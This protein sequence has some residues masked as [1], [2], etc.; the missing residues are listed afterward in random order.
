MRTK[1]N[2]ISNIKRASYVTVGMLLG[3]VTT[4]T[5]QTEPVTYSANGTVVTYSQNDIGLNM[6]VQDARGVTT[7]FQANNLNLITSEQSA[8]RGLTQYTYDDAGNIIRQVSE[9]GLVFKRDYDDQNRLIKE[10]MKQNGV[11]RKVHKYTY[12]SC[13]NGA[14]FL[15]KVVSHGHVTKY[16]YTENGSIARVSTRYSGEDSFE[17]TRYSY[18]PD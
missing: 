4:A 15:C 7:T 10:V 8:E 5:A 6:S 1:N 16:A 2:L 9:G 12:D 3:T 17:T 11:E 18:E 14:G 13:Q